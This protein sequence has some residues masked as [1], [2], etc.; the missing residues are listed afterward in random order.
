WPQNYPGLGTSPEKFAKLVKRMSGGRIDI[1]VF[2]AGT[3]VPALE[4]F[5]AVSQGSAELG[6]GAAYYWK[7]KHPAAPFFTAVPFGFTA[8]E[9]NG[10]LH[11]GGGQQLWDELYA[12]FNLKP[13]A[14]GNTDRKSTRL[15]SSHVKISYA[16]F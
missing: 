16:V 4:V 5:D 12:R 6:H 2:G 8:Q 1:K 10:W 9:Q 7:G 15:N 11:H 13:F 3:M 14:C